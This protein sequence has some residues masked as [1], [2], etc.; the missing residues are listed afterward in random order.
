MTSKPQHATE[1]YV[2]MWLP[3]K[4]KPIVVGKMVQDSGRYHF[5]Y[6]QSYRAHQEAT[7]LS[8]VELPLETGTFSPSG[9]HEI[10]ACLRDGSPDAW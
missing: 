4:I 7:P 8:P 5:T 3:E 1:A 10:P 9:L 2:W 6:G